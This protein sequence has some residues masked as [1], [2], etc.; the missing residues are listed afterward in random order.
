[1]LKNTKNNLEVAISE[2]F[3]ILSYGCS[4]VIVTLVSLDDA[5]FS[6]FHASRAAGKAA[7]EYRYLVEK[8]VVDSDQYTKISQASQL[9]NEVSSKM[10]A[11]ILC[12]G[13]WSF[14]VVEDATD[15]ESDYWFKYFNDQSPKVMSDQVFSDVVLMRSTM[16][17]NEHIDPEF[18]ASLSVWLRQ[19]YDRTIV[20]ELD[21]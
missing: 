2:I 20:V 21:E 1:M 5:E 6:L 17:S 10:M 13:S 18:M 8:G 4:V 15:E 19:Q 7:S 9:L 14:D 3:V 12:N 11:E 16:R